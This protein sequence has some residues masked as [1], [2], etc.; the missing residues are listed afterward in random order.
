MAK[1][2]KGQS[3]NPGG[4]PKQA[5]GLRASLNEKYGDDGAKLVEMLG[6]FLGSRNE[7]LRFEALK[8]A[9]AYR[10]GQPTQRHEHSEEVSQVPSALTFVFQQ[11]PDSDNRT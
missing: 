1:F 8:L 6:R 11:A 2:S 9:M 7:K 3:G 10:F 5:A 4:R